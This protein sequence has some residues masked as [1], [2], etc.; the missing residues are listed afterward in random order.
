MSIIDHTQ[1]EMMVDTDLATSFPAGFL[2]G[3]ATASYQIEGAVSEDGR[4]PSI[5][6][7]FAE[8]PGKTHR[9]ETG[10][11][12]VDHYHRMPEDVALMAQLGLGAYRFSISWSRVLPDGTGPVNEPGLD[13][14]DRLVDELLAKGITPLATLYHWDLP[15]TLHDRGGWLNR[16]TALVF[17]DYAEIVARRLGDRVDWWLTQ[18]EP[19]C[20]AFLGYGIGVHAPGIEDMQAAATA[21]HHVLLAHGLALPRL[22]AHTR[23]SAR[24][25]ITLN[26]TPVYATDNSP[27][28]LLGVEKEDIFQNRWFVEPIF[29]ASY[30]E[31]L[32]TNMGVQP[33]PIKDGDMA[34]ISA[35]IDFLGVNNYSRILLRSRPGSGNAAEHT[36]E[37]VAP[38]PGACYTEMGW[39]VYPRGLTDLL[40][41]LHRDYA[42][43]AFVVT[44]N[45]A[46]FED[47]WDGGHRV[48]DP[49]RLE[50]LRE[51]IRAVGQAI[52]QGVPVQG[53]FA[54]SLMDNFEWAE[55][56]SKRF[57][58]VYIDYA[59][60]RRIIKDSGYW[61]ANFLA[62]QRGQESS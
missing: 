53:Y 29:R 51:Y 8:T 14:Y 36:Y 55:G 42:P 1:P 52:A 32:F 60:Q 3:T 47:M 21:G 13:F 46:A 43:Q 41:R 31:H 2:W 15:L 62:A 9:G 38:I 12:A 56:Y 49:R 20:T 37:T 61:Y 26:F 27:E 44:E 54:W 4:R 45:G 39:E 57:G 11:V 33:P 28:T 10:A 35:P 58:I 25:G 5:W 22:R 7:A 6:D 59:S 48:S 19:W 23:S 17:A 34:L 30:P 40:C 16:G 50:Y 18:N 24:L